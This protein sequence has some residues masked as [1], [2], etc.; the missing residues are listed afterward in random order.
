MAE[1]LYDPQTAERILSLGEL[2]VILGSVHS[3]RFE[4]INDSYSRI[5]FSDMPIEK[6]HEFLKEY[7]RHIA[8]MVEKTDFDVLTHLTCPLRY[9]NGKYHRNV[10]ILRHRDE[11]FSIF[12][13]I[14]QKDIALEINTSGF[15][16][17][18]AKLMPDLALIQSYKK[19]G[20]KR[21]TLASDA[22][23]PQNIG[24]GFSETAAVLQ[25]IGFDGYCVFR[26]R[27]AEL[28]TF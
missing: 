24:K 21:I 6:I 18:F 9:I 7:F 26:R 14:I 25:D 11:I 16:G 10:D 28:K 23:I 19:M 13:Q 5:D 4:N 20:G 17:N 27:N 12:E 8:E 22:H 2:D 15:D 1:Y 3:V